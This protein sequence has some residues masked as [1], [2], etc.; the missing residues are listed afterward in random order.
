MNT[1]A[2]ATGIGRMA[3]PLYRKAA[4]NAI[5]EAIFRNALQRID[6]GDPPPYHLDE[7]SHLEPK[8]G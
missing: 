2:R 1:A 8:V 7:L 5:V 3:C 4:I 6:V